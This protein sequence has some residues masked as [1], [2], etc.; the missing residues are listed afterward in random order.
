MKTIAT[1]LLL[2]VA[3][4]ASAA[5]LP[6]WMAGSWGGT[7]GGVVMEEHWTLPAAGLMV[8]MHRDVSPKGKAS[9]EFMRIEQRKGTLV[10]LAMPGG[11][12]AT[13]F[14]MKSQ[15]GARIVFENPDHDF[16]QRIIYWRDAG[17]LCARVEGTIAGNASGEEW[18]WR[19]LTV[20]PL[21]R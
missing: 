14:R 19:P 18:C 11:R 17:R 4:I 5:E 15:D 3:T 7:T 6:S 16:P 8:G 21:D 13:P 20:G 10:F 1:G 2:V 12:P 9:F